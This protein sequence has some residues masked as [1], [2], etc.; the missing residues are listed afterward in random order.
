MHGSNIIKT[1][2]DADKSLKLCFCSEQGNSLCSRAFIC[3]R[4]GTDVCDKCQ[5]KLKFE[6]RKLKRKHESGDDW[7]QP[8]SSVNIKLLTPESREK[9]LG[10]T[11]AERYQLKLQL[12]KVMD[13][14]EK[15]ELDSK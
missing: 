11:R 8:N 12:Q 7:A 6:R 14:I 4:V 2:F 15:V 1:K 10:R 5:E 9:R 13:K 3:F